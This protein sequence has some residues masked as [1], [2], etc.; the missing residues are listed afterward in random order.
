MKKNDKRF[1]K[2]YIHTGCTIKLETRPANVDDPEGWNLQEK[3]DEIR[4]R[5]EMEMPMGIYILI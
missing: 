3:I 2:T 1:F 4:I 5:K